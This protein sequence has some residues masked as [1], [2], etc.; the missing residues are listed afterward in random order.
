MEMSSV[1]F[2]GNG[3]K[4]IPAAAPIP[5]DKKHLL[6]NFMDCTPYYPITTSKI[7]ALNGRLLVVADQ[8]VSFLGLHA[9]LLYVV[10][11]MAICADIHLH[12][13]RGV[14][15]KS[16]YAVPPDI[17]AVLR[18]PILLIHLKVIGLANVSMTCLAFHFSI[19]DMGDVREKYTGRLFGIYVPGDL[20]VLRDIFFEKNFFV[21]TVTQD[22]IVAIDTLR[23]FWSAAKR[24]V[25]SEEMT[26]FTTI[27]HQLVMHGMAEIDGLVFF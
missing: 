15:C 12:P 2:Q 14:S 16:C 3:D 1:S 18:N 27:I 7:K 25:F 5:N 24:T 10:S 23:Q 21:F 22:L 9:V 4:V 8:T 13:L 26:A 11:D 17:P 20:P 19:F 6:D